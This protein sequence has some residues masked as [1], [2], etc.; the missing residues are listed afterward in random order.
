MKHYIGLKFW[1]AIFIYII[2]QLVYGFFYVSIRLIFK[3]PAQ[4]D[5]FV[6]SMQYLYILLYLP[7]VFIG[8]KKQNTKIKNL[9]TIPDI[10][11]VLKMFAIVLLARIIVILPLNEP[12]D[13]IK[14]L[15]NSQLSITG[16]STRPL[17]PLRDLCSV[18]I[19][20]IIE[21]L[22]FR[23]F[24]L[25]N[26]LK[27]YSPIYAILLSSI[28]FA[29]HHQDIE[30]LLFYFALGVIFGILFY[31]SKSLTISTMAHII[32]NASS[33]FLE[34]Y[35]ELDFINSF[36]VITI[37]ISASLLL[38]KLLKE[39]YKIGRKND[40]TNSLHGFETLQE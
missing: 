14:S 26:F 6:I 22:F 23:G 25:K 29:F 11:T 34:K 5:A 10:Q 24:I 17:F 16:L 28:I 4:S 32:W 1:H 30:S 40:T 21:E 18:L 37:Y 15:M 35:I 33:F 2:I 12:I 27:R 36:F 38:F 39:Y 9:Y 20:P 3:Y 13:V 19:V 31:T 7:I 8:F